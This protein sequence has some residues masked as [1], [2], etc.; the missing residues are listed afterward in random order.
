MCIGILDVKEVHGTKIVQDA[1]LETVRL[2][3]LSH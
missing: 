3:L 2:V 1:A